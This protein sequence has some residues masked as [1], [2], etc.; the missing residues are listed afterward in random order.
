[1]KVKLSQLK[2]NEIQN[3]ILPKGFIE[4]VIKYKTTLGE[5]EN[6]T[7]EEA[8]SNFQRDAEPEKELKIWEKITEKYQSLIKENNIIDFTQKQVPDM[9]AQ[10]LY[11]ELQNKYAN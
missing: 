6:S 8:V 4:R 11:Q 9:T 2:P 7:L 1:M 5:V 3:P 10:E